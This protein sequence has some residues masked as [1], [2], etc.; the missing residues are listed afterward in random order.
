M[1]TA[2]TAELTIRMVLGL[3][4]IVGMLGLG[5]RLV[6]RRVGGPASVAIDVRG[7]QVLSKAS[8]VAVIQVGTRHLLVGVTESGV[9]LLAE[10]DDLV[11]EAAPEERPADTGGTDGAAAET[12]I[13]LTESADDAE[14]SAGTRPRLTP[15]G[16]AAT[17]DGANMLDLLRQRTVRK[18]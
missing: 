11:A 13:D 14:P 3:A 17:L 7:R 15:T 8:S 2:T 5:T 4:V 10:G 1:D 12:A 18:G 16:L 9:S 6:R